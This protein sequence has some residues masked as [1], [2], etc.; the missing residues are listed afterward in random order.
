M[1]LRCGGQL[2]RE[3][4]RA[5]RRLLPLLLGA[6]ILFLLSNAYPIV[7]MD[8]KGVHSQTT[9]LDSVQ[10]LYADNMALIAILVFITTILFPLVEMLMLLY[11]LIH[12]ARRRI[13][14][15]F[16]RVVRC[17][18]LTRPWGMIEVFMVGVLVTVAKLSA[19]A[20]VLPG[21]ALWSFA[22]LVVVL[23][24]LMAFDPRELWQHLENESRRDGVLSR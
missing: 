17:I 13:P 21:I 10:A 5:Y 1:C 18:Q 8:L 23:A 9:L 24:V 3:N 19:M 2:Y 11:L 14:A 16:A 4:N 20:E 22:T 7:E 12:M 15:N 6:L